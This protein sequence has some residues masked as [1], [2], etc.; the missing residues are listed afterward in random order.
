MALDSTLTPAGR[1]GRSAARFGMI[2]WAIVAT[3]VV[4]LLLGRGLTD[5]ILAEGCTS[6]GRITLGITSIVAVWGLMIGASAATLVIPGHPPDPGR[7][8]VH[9][10]LGLSGSPLFVVVAYVVYVSVKAPY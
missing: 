7:I 3:A 9:A 4:L 2:A 8:W 5:P 6:A 1:T 10:G